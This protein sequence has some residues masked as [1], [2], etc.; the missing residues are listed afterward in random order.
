VKST[1]LSRTK[2]KKTVI[3]QRIHTAGLP[4]PR[5][6]E[7]GGQNTYLVRGTRFQPQSP[8]KQPPL[9]LRKNWAQEL[10][11]KNESWEDVRRTEQEQ[12]GAA[13]AGSGLE[14]VAT[15]IGARRRT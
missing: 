12:L 5:N 2:E 3:R 6:Q 9:R 1:K 11:L 15:A 8:E 14:V 7:L 13:T 10:G 4:D